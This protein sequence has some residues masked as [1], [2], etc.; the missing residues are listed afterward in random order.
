[1]T[2]VTVAQE[3]ID[4]NKDADTLVYAVNQVQKHTFLRDVSRNVLRG[5]LANRD[6]GSMIKSAPVGMC[7]VY[8]DESGTEQK[9]V[10]YDEEFRKPKGWIYTLA[11]SARTAE[12]E[13]MKWAFHEY[14]DTDCGLYT[15]AQGLVERGI[16][17]RA[18]T[19]IAPNALRKL[20]QNLKYAGRLEFGRFAKGKFHSVNGD[21][22]ICAAD[23]VP[24][25]GAQKR[26]EPFR[27]IENSYEPL[28]DLATF[29][30][31]QRKLERRR[32][33]RQAQR[34]NAWLLSGI[35]RC[36]LCGG[37]MSSAG[38]NDTGRL[39][40]R[41]H[42]HV[43]GTCS[44]PCIRKDEIE[45]FVGRTLE[46]MILGDDTLQ[47]IREQIIGE[48]KE[49]NP[50]R[51]LPAI[52]TRL[53]GLKREIGN[54]QRNIKFVDDPEDMQS[55]RDELSDV[56]RQQR[57]TKSVGDILERPDAPD[58]ALEHVAF[59]IVLDLRERFATADTSRMRTVLRDVFDHITLQ[60][61]QVGKRHCFTHGQMVLRP[62]L[63]TAIT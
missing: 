11:V 22:E 19:H 38:A 12:V 21:G 5:Q 61:E 1:V 9:R 45:A 59:E 53:K 56:R 58:A 2:L 7:R 4:W 42:G 8:S 49:Q 26:R 14:A 60:F 31:V 15:L 29:D 25:H 43:K 46:E 24:V 57:E 17:S 35:L 52:R 6:N 23:A 50:D 33:G 30:R 41:C 34:S 39:P 54:L 48:L 44:G 27:V 55:I 3:V 63:V 37:S 47:R 62:F 40:Y 16:R 13:A 51:Q 32:N 18:G 28:I 10:E 36:G 20:L